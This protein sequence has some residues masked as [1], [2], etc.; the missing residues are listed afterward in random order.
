[1]P[2]IESRH[3][4]EAPH[5][6]V[7]ATKP[8]GTRVAHRVR[9][10][11]IPERSNNFVRN[12]GARPADLRSRIMCW[13]LRPAIRLALM[14]GFQNVNYAYV[15]GLVRRLHLGEGCSIMNTVFNVVSG[16]IYVGDDTIF[17]HG[18]YVLTGVHRFYEGRRAS[19]QVSCPIPETPIDGRDIRIGSGCWLGAGAVVLGG[20]TIGD[21]VIVG[22]GA[23]VTS[24]VPSGS[25]V[26]G[27]PAA[28]IKPS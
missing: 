23:V 7:E 12:S 9:R 27:V 24:D 16:D 14:C 11:V 28:L 25:F 5:Q 15:H 1:M 2:R 26:A 13:L 19:L 8:F 17:S 21:N 4:P 3:T 20:V 10:A 6:S 18:C 22:A